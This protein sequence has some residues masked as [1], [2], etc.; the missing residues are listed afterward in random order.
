MSNI[1]EFLRQRNNSTFNVDVDLSKHTTYK[2]GGVC[3]VFVEP[4]DID[5]LIEIVEYIK[6][7]GNKYFVIGNGS[8]VILP[9]GYNNI[10]VIKLTK[11]CEY[12]ITSDY[13]YAQAGILVPKLALELAYK[14]ISCLEF[15]SG[16]PGTLGGCVFMNAGAYGTEMSDVIMSVE[17]YDPVSNCVMEIPLEEMEFGY[18]H[19]ILHHRDWIVLGVKIKYS[20]AP[21]EEIVGLI[22]DRR[23]RRVE[24][25][26]IGQATAG[27]VFRNF[28]D[29]STWKVIDQCGL[30][31]YRIGDAVVSDIHCNTIVNMGSATS[32]EVVKLIEE[33]KRVVYEKTSREL[34]VEQ[35]IIKWDN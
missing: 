30:R 22:N 34:I 28:D 31:G 4:N 19:S 29:I 11:I 15:V 35:R 13:V 17:A 33:I 2:T 24:S 5:S 21:S 23:H 7:N 8:N 26:P 9:D 6:M 32:C 12:E 16:V 20:C 14:G 10:V 3:S 25:Q 1:I 18:R 27:S